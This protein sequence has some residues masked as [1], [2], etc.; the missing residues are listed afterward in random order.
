M[1]RNFNIPKAKLFLSDIQASEGFQL[2]AE[3]SVGAGFLIGIM[4]MVGVF[5]IYIAF[6]QLNQLSDSPSI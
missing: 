6:L 3:S 2:V 5:L 1:E 4:W